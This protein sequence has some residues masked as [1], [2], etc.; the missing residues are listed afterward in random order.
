[1]IGSE[2]SFSF[3]L[4]NA[5]IQVSSNL[6]AVSF[7][8][9]LY[10]GFAIFEKSFI[11]LLQNLVWTIR[12]S[13]PWHWLVVAASQFPSFSPCPPKSL[14]LRL[15]ILVQFLLLP[16]SD[17]SHISKLCWNFHIFAGPCLEF[18]N[19]GQIYFQILKNQQ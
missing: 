18:L 14:Y 2:M 17:I 1:M 12:F 13:L 6:K 16:W 7:S 19:T 11:N 4:L 9:K 8:N 15:C 10:S 3:N 5:S